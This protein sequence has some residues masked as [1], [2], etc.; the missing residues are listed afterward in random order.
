MRI[1][2][3]GNIEWQDLPKIEHPF[4]ARS[5]IERA[6]FDCHGSQ[7]GGIDEVLRDGCY[8]PYG[9]TR[10]RWRL[11]RLLEQVKQGEVF[12]VHGL[13]SK[14]AFPIVRWAG[15]GQDQNQGRWIV[16]LPQGNRFV[17]SRLE[18]IIRTLRPPKGGGLIA[19]SWLDQAVGGAREIVNMLGRRAAAGLSESTGIGFVEKGTG[20]KI[21]LTKEGQ[22][23]LPPTNPAQL[24]GA[25]IVRDS[26]AAAAAVSTIMALG[27]RFRSVVRNPEAFAADLRRALTHTA[28]EAE[29]LGKAGLEQAKRRLGH[30]T[31]GR[32]RD[33][34]HGPDD[35]T[36]K[37]GRLTEWE[38]KGTKTDSKAVAINTKGERQSSRLKNRRRAITMTRKEKKIGL[39]SNRQGGPY[40]REEI[41]LW[42]EILH[43][44]GN[45]RHIS[46][47]TNTGS[48]EVKVYER[49]HR[50]N[51]ARTLDDFRMENFD[52]MKQ[53][54]GEAFKK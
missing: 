6:F 48:G 46:V 7:V 27:S 42:R 28:S 34:Y 2:R 45:K 12:L 22:D 37:D 13:G 30:R 9:L 39:P 18:R 11:D 10:D 14:P 17:K 23:L 5:Q 21:D 29:A 44:R 33:R 53:A 38:A 8:L 3:A 26:Q 52:H 36:L 1:K 16:T 4:F 51:I 20:R 40:T 15:N 41:D 49:N 43:R 25:Q 31:D 35:M 19:S 32:Y 50:G 54:I 47:H 24:Q